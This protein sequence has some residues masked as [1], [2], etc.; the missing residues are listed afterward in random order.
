[1][2]GSEN[3]WKSG[4]NSK[5]KENIYALHYERSNLYIEDPHSYN[6]CSTILKKKF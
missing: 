5:S 4:N 3:V 6:I 1:M 2:L